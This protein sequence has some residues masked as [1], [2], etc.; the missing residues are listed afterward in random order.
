V[1]LRLHQPAFTFGLNW[2]IWSITWFPSST[3]LLSSTNKSR[4]YFAS[5][6]KAEKKRKTIFCSSTCTSCNL[7]SFVPIQIFFW[8]SNTRRSRVKLIPSNSRYPFTAQKAYQTLLQ[9]GTKNGPQSHESSLL[10]LAAR[11]GTHKKEATT[12]KKLHR[13]RPSQETD[14]MSKPSTDNIIIKTIDGKTYHFYQFHKRWGFHK[15]VDCYVCLKQQSSST[16]HDPLPLSSASSISIPSDSGTTRL[17]MSA[18]ITSIL[19][20]HDDYIRSYSAFPSM[21]TAA[22]SR[23]TPIRD[24]VAAT[25]DS[26]SF[27]ILVDNGASRCMTKSP[28]HFVGTPKIVSKQVTAGLGAGTVTLEGTVR[29]R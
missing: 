14:W 17:T 8:P 5:F 2:E 6:V 10:V 28:R 11:Y 12:T 23:T 26:D 25:F 15:E 29:W 13:S 22:P 1:K 9:E 18:A 21:I 3:T 16:N 27:V 4:T 7:T 20:D 19:D 24:M